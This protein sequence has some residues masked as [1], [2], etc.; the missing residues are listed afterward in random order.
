[1]TSRTSQIPLLKENQYQERYFRE[2]HSATVSDSLTEH[3]A[4]HKRCMMQDEIAAHRL[5][6][7]VI[8]LVT[9]G[10]GLHTFGSRK[11][12]VRKNM[13]GFIGP[14]VV[15]SWKAD[16]DDNRGYI[17]SFSEEFFLANRADKQ[18]LSTLPLFQIEGDPILCL[19]NEDADE[20]A[21]I[22]SMIEKESSQSA[23]ADVLRGY[24]QVLV[25]K[26]ISK[27]AR[28][29]KN[30]RTEHPSS[31][32]RIVKAFIETFSR[33]FATIKSGSEIKQKK[34][35]DYAKQLGVSQNYL[36]DTTKAITGKSAGQLLRSQLLKQASVCLTHSSKSISEISYMLGFDDPSYFTRFYKKQTG[37]LPSDLRKVSVKSAGDPV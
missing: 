14:N 32:L 6:F 4:L 26:A 11:H 28:E 1:M 16:H 22:F 30:Q 19:T 37:H 36:N 3:F 31:G 12:Y 27:Y 9:S 2:F 33:D 29:H 13:L 35:S 34:I 10:E 25:G 23:S 17:C 5:D 15:N 18:Y 8:F 21:A 20:F 7:Y 24:L